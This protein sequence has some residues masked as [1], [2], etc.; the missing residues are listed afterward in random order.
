MNT[1]LTELERFDDMCILATNKPQFLDDAMYRRISLA[2]E[3]RKPDLIL[4]E[5]IWETLRPE[6]LNVDKDV[7]YKELARKF[8]LSG[9]FIK[10]VWLSAVSLM[11]SRQGDS[12]SLKDLETA[13]R[14]QLVGSVKNEDLDRHVIPTCGIESIVA[15]EDVSKALKDIVD[16]KKAQSVLFSQWG[17]DKLHRNQSGVSALFH[18]P[19]GTGA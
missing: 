16:H 8:E 15:S 1:C 2:V 18:G 3:F 6:K 12:V 13:A 11:V 17:F 4:R 14:E 7:D 9:G 10:N 5:K 19:P